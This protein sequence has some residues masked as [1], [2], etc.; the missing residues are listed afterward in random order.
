MLICIYTI[1]NVGMGPSSEKSKS[2]YND[3][4]I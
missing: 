2:E 3:E 4:V 1:Q